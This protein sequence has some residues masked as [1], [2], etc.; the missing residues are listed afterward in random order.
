MLRLLAHLCVRPY[1]AKR[2]PSKSVAIVVPLSNRP[3]LS[4]EEEISLRHLRHYLGRYDIYMI[5]PPNLDVRFEGI[6]VKRFADKFFGSAAAH[7]HLTYAPL[8]YRA[9]ADYRFIF[10]YHLDSLV[11]S[12]QLEDWCNA[13]IDYIGPPWIQCEDSP[14]V[15]KPRVGNGGFT[16]L[17]VEA[18][19]K[20]LYNRYQREPFAYWL[21][22]F[23]RNGRQVEPVVRFLRRLQR[24]FPRSKWVNR[25]VEEWDKMQDPSPN[26][27]NNDI[28]WSD[29]AAL[30]MP[31]FKVAT[32]EQGLRFA[33]EVSPRTCLAMNH[34]QMPFGCH[35]WARYDRGFWEPFLLP[36]AM[37]HERPPSHANQP[38]R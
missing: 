36:E 9:F 30:Y 2:P 17:R 35:A 37:A 23:A 27:R 4:P 25:P 13:G 14:W 12:D 28:F 5:A 21:D 22:M 32:L 33:F 6:R 29:R 38:A 31:E 8:F 16:L 26:N 34:G 1:R 15:T 7:N 10:F 19:L 3:D 20:A 24:R 18:A 11:F